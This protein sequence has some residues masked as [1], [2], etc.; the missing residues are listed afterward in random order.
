VR[1]PGQV[2]GAVAK[3]ALNTATGDRSAGAAASRSPAVGRKRGAQ[4]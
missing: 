1:A 4:R 3:A 2:A